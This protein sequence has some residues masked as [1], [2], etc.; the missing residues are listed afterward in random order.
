MSGFERF[1][2]AVQVGRGSVRAGHVAVTSQRI[3]NAYREVP[4]AP[5]RTEPRPTKPLPPVTP[6]S[7]ILL[8][9]F[10]VR[11]PD[12]FDLNGVAEVLPALSLVIVQPVAALTV[13]HPGVL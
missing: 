13:I 4:R 5:P 12:V 2:V 9:L 7:R 1:T 3:P 6:D 10:S 11:H 8:P